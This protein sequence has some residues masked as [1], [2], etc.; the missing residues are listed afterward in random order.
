MQVP[1][2]GILPSVYVCTSSQAK[3]SASALGI[4]LLTVAGRVCAAHAAM[5]RKLIGE[6]TEGPV[7]ENSGNFDIL[8]IL[9]CFEFK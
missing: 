4:L 8:K 3:P 2:E 1:T 5:K 7:S 9:Q 6:W